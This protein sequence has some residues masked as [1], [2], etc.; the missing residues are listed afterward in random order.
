MAADL[1]AALMANAWR[2][3]FEH[4]EMSWILEDNVAAN[5]SLEAMG[6]RQYKRYRIYEWN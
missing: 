3:G 6:A 5:R 4:I 2:L 1:Y